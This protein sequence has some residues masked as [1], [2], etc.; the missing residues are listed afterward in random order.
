M[1]ISCSKSL[2]L[3]IVTEYPKSGGSWVSQMLSDYLEVP[4]PRNQFPK[5]QS[6]IMQGHYLYFPTMKN[7]F[8]I[9][10]DGRDIMVS[11]YYYS[12]FK[13]DRFNA[14]VV[15]TT[16]RELHF[17]D[18]NDIK[19]NL[20]KFI[21]YKFTHKKHP[22]FTWSEF[23]TSWIDKDVAFIRYENLLKEPV[24]ELSTAIFKVFK[25]EPDENKLQ[26]IIEKYSFKNLAGRNPG[27]ENKQ[28]FIRKGIAGDWKNHFSQESK[29]IFG[30]YAG[31][32]LI[33][34]GYAKDFTW[35]TNNENCQHH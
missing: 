28:S 2:P 5:F 11:F 15:S 13:N 14:R 6:S 16:R 22:R 9:L 27:E 1:A 30:Y 19:N 21:E 25:I 4:F 24:K 34:L 8:V 12:L 10:R 32:E 20:P 3:Y 17:K 33:Q 35:I 7:V 23:I 18:Y 31:N 26:M 29:E